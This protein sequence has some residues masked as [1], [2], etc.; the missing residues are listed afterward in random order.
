MNSHRDLVISSDGPAALD[1]GSI[2]FIGAATVLL[3]YAGFTILTDPSFLHRGERVH[4]G[5]GLHATRR[6]DPAREIDEL[7]PLD[8][9]LLSHMHEDHF[10][11]IAEARLDRSVPL[12]TTG[13]AAAI[14][15][16]KGF[17]V[18]RSLRT[19]EALEIEKGGVRLRVTSMPAQHGP[20]PV[21]WLLPP[22]M[23]SLLEFETSPGN[24]ALR[25]YISGD[26]LIHRALYE[27]PRRYPHIDLALLHLGGTR[28]LGILVTMDGDQGAEAMRLLDPR[29]AIPIHYDDFTVFK[30]PLDEFQRAVEAAG[31][32]ERVRYLHRGEAY[33]FEIAQPRLDL[34]S[35]AAPSMHT[36]P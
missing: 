6:T 2:L 17:Q 33:T 5:Y 19:W 14:L 35:R 3:R 29:E 7:P 11:R 24:I 9:V 23:G 10:D 27:I 22:V 26:T 30:S 18:V 21:S 4:L 20:A 36:T 1:Q 16:E 32:D 28:L 12:I 15:S 25:L 31:L 34:G 13:H 8:L